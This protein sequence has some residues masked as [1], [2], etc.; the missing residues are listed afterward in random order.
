MFSSQAVCKWSRFCASPPACDGVTV[1]FIRHSDWFVMKCQ[2]AFIYVTPTETSCHRLPYSS[3][4]LV[5]C[6]LSTWIVW[7]FL[8]RWFYN[9]GIVLNC[10]V[11]FKY[12]PPW[13]F[14][15][16]S[17]RVFHGAGVFWLSRVLLSSWPMS[18][19]QSEGLCFAPSALEVLADRFP[20]V[21]PFVLEPRAVQ[22]WCKA[23]AFRVLFLCSFAPTRVGEVSLLHLSALVPPQK[24]VGHVGGVRVQVFVRSEL[25]VSLSL[26]ALHIFIQVISK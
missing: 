15:P 11:V 14:F 7:C 5:W 23:R 8:M 22:S 4:G 9:L 18:G 2:T 17:N 21:W 13:C 26:P 10:P 1:F 3:F 16:S 12:F 6:P 25:S 24:S 19:R 20:K